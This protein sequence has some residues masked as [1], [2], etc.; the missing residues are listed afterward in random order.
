MADVGHYGIM[1]DKEDISQHAIRNIMTRDFVLGFLAFFVFFVAI[2]TLTPT[3]PI[4]LTKLGSSTREIGVLVGTLGIASLICRLLVGGALRKYSEKRVMM[5]GAMIF[6]FTFIGFIV[7]RPFWPFLAVRFFQGVAFSCMDTA[8][9][10]CAIGVVPLVYRTRAIG[11][12]LLAPSFAMAI[13][14]PFGMFLMNRY[15]FTVLLLTGTALSLCAF[16]LALSLSGRK[17]STPEHELPVNSAFLFERKIVVPAIT[18]FL[19]YITWSSVAAFFSLYAVQ[20]GATNPG[21]FFSAMASMLILGRIFGGK[22]FE[23]WKKEKIILTF[24]LVAMLALVILS[25]SKTLPM[26]I[27]VGMLWGMAG[28]F[29]FP[30]CMSYAL[31]YSG[32]SGGIALGTYQAFMDSGSALGPVIMGVIIPFAGYR[33]MFLCLALICTLN[34]C[35][36]QLYVRKKRNTVLTV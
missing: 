33:I 3:M 17:T 10:A 34:L 22:V 16:L 19:H 29:L 31:E 18:S 25:F 27:F 12:I 15:S 23:R 8:A 36:F 6:V 28:A 32:T 13:A 30:A 4:Y 26:F 24:M 14:A 1:Q 9:I 11:Y 5:F 7:F 2:F 21:L 20:C 35:Y